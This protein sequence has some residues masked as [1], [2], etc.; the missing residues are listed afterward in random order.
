MNNET[1]NKKPLLGSIKELD[2]SQELLF[3]FKTEENF[4]QALLEMRKPTLLLKYSKNGSAHFRNFYITQNY[5]RLCWVSPK[6]LRAESSKK[7][8][9]IFFNFLLVFLKDIVKFIRGRQTE[10][11]KKHKKEEDYDNISFSIVYLLNSGSSNKNK[12]ETTTI[13]LTCK[14]SK[15]FE[16][17]FYGLKACTYAVK[18][19][20]DLA[21]L[22]SLFLAGIYT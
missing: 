11:F 14:D 21:T 17:W 7:I 9:I 12:F 13:D 19:N 1:I 3:F 15:E 4:Y 8:F 6:K 5:E 16:I 20:Y 2:P 18:N 10:K 22:E